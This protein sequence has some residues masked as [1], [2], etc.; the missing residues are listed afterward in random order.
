MDVALARD[1]FRITEALRDRFNSSDDVAFGFGGGL[2][3]RAVAQQ[4]RR[5]HRPGPC[6][7]V[8]R[9][10]FLPRQLLQVRIDIGRPNDLTLTLLVVE[11]E[12]VVAGDVPAGTDDL[13]QGAVIQI[14]LVLDPALAPERETQAPTAD[15]DVAVAQ[16][17]QSEGA[18][19]F[20]VLVVA[21]PNQGLLE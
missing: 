19:L 7:E 13:R 12:Q 1:G 6:P 20:R 4:L 17:R 5:V 3:F 2:V 11:L 16:R 18:V 15:V 8:L 10:V 14:D 21:D 9:G